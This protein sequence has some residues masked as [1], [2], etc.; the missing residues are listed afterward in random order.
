MPDCWA[1][2]TAARP[3]ASANPPRDSF[4]HCTIECHACK[5]GSGR[6]LAASGRRDDGNLVSVMGCYILDR[7]A[8]DAN[9]LRESSAV[10]LVGLVEIADHSLLD[11]LAPH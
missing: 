11:R 4:S 3:A 6:G 10:F 9:D 8:V 5:R 7:L 1:L 2:A